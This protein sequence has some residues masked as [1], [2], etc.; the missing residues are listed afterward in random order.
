MNKKVFTVLA[1][2]IIS[3]AVCTPVSA[4]EPG[5]ASMD[6]GYHIYSSNPSYFSEEGL[7]ALDNKAL[8]IAIKSS[9]EV[10]F[11]IN[12]Y[13]DND[14]IEYAENFYTNA[15]GNENGI[16]FLVTKD[17]WYVHCAGNTGE[18]FSEV[19]KDKIWD[20]YNKAKTYYDGVDAYLNIVSDKLADIKPPS[21]GDGSRLIDTADVLTDDEQWVLKAYFTRI[22]DRY[23]FDIAS[24]IVS[25]F[26]GMSADEYADS[27]YENCN[28][29]RGD[30]KDGILLVANIETKQWATYAYGRGEAAFTEAGQKYMYDTYGP[31]LDAKRYAEALNS[32]A[33]LCDRFLTQAESGVPFNAENLP[34]IPQEKILPRLVDDADILTDGQEKDLLNKLDAVSEDKGCDVAVVTVYS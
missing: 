28:F 25:S 21:Y 13:V 32:Y 26:E 22:A 34:V 1:A 15:S 29:G 30:T 20:E 24:V 18:I 14:T 31:I 11:A 33:G 5:L 3:L 27:L 7:A 9:T 17:Y 23:D 19:D 4:H 16:L 8:N 2:I 6:D 12:E 10:L